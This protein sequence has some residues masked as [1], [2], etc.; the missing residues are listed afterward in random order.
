MGL[1]F[2]T[3]FAKLF[4]EYL[5]F[6][7]PLLVFFSSLTFGIYTL[8]SSNVVDVVVICT[9]NVSEFDERCRCTVCK[10]ML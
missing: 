8:I 3:M 7:R 9:L 4:F 5:G 1:F 10:Y 6:T 2:V